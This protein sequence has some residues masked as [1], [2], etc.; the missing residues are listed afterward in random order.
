MPGRR[1]ANPPPT[2]RK[3]GRGAFGRSGDRPRPPNEGDLDV[4]KR[5]TAFQAFFREH[6]EHWNRRF[7]YDRSEG[8]TR[9]EKIFRREGQPADGQPITVRGA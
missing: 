2:G 1:P 8:K 6:S 3:G 5:L 4:G 9:K 7:D